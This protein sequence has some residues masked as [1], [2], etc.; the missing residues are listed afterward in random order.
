MK[1][2]FG[3]QRSRRLHT[4]LVAVALLVV[5][6]PLVIGCRRTTRPQALDDDRALKQVLY[7]QDLYN[8]H[9]QEDIAP[10]IT[11]V[12]DSMR[13]EGRNPYY[14]AAV[15]ILIDRLFSEG[16]FSEAD[17]LAVRIEEEAVNDR[18]ST[19]MAMAK[20]VR[21][22]MF[23]KLSQTDKA[24][25]ELAPAAD[26]IA[27]PSKS[28]SAFG[29]A[30]SI[31]EWLWIIVRELGDTAAMNQAGMR[32][33]HL[34]EQYA[35]VNNWSDSTRH[36]PVTALAFRAQDEF[37]QGNIRQT[38]ALLDSANSLMLP[39]LPPRAY[40]HLFEVRCLVRASDNDRSGAIAD[41][42]TL[43]ATHKNF[44]WFYLKDL[45]LK[46]RV[47]NQIGHHEQSVRAFA[48]YMAFHDSLS[49]AITD[50]R[51]NDLTVLYRSEIDHEQQRSHRTRLFALGAVIMLLLLLLGISYLHA[52]GIKKKN[53]ILVERLREEDL[54]KGS[55]Q[56]DDELPDD[57]SPAIERLDRHMLSRRPYCDPALG[58]KELA[59]FLGLTPDA[60]GQLIKSE[61]GMSVKNY[62]NGFR[63][64]EA[65]RMLGCESSE[66]IADIAARLGFGTARTLQRAFKEKY[67]MSPSQYRDT[68]KALGQ[69]PEE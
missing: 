62:I 4:I 46:A 67:D 38:R 5:A 40:E 63:L 23:F 45:Y 68:A 65:R 26:F 50:S 12:I 14:F 37:S 54:A 29:T 10:E 27:D 15:N 33:A 13:S 17:S 6:M 49:N 30:S 56:P 31:L 2:C 44:P 28:A 24:F 43:L 11:S 42:D 69:I 25:R 55:G 19:S 32:F 51:L 34:V 39:A 60:L 66:T 1:D 53:R 7:V 61:R 47:L 3:F 20:R 64:E 22:Q 36:Y 16:R 41:V 58:R 35:A 52:L 8:N 59:D 57:E 9:P 21:A 48:E 18:D